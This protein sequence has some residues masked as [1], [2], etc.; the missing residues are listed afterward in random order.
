M[1]FNP[2]SG[3]LLRSHTKHKSRFICLTANADNAAERLRDCPVV[4]LDGKLIGRVES[5]LVDLL[6]KELCF[7]VLA[8]KNRRAAVVIPWQLLYFDSSLVRL[9]YYTCSV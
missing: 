5:I 7:V 6:S 2:V 4:S 8:C 9:V 1:A 3:N